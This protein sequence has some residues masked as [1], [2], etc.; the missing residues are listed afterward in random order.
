MYHKYDNIRNL[1]YVV[2]LKKI[3]IIILKDICDQI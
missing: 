1:T 2:M 3:Y